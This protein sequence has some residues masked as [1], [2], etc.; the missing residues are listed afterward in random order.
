MRGRSLEVRLRIRRCLIA[1]LL[2]GLLLS[3]LEALFE[4]LHH[5][6][7][8]LLLIDQLLVEDLVH[9]GNRLL[10]FIQH[11]LQLAL[12]LRHDLSRHSLLELV[13]NDLTNLLVIQSR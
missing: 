10:N 2:L 7:A 5:L 9:V 4:N 8:L 12:E 13:M 1:L 6:V 11:L 3:E